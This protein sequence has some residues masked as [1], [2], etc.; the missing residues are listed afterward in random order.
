[1]KRPRDPVANTSPVVGFHF[2]CEADYEV[3]PAE[4]GKFWSGVWVV[5][6]GLCQPAIDLKGYVALHSA[7]SEPSYRQGRIVGWKMERRSKGKTEMGIS[8]LL[9][10]LPHS[11]VWFGEGAGERG[12]RRLED[13]PR[14]QPV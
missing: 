8:F 9:E 12:Y 5:K 10:P 1:M 11:F 3:T 6:E 7:K 2:V 14:Y 13:Q 4:N